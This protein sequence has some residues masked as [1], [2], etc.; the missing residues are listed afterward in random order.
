MYHLTILQ[1]WCGIFH[2]R[3]GRRDTNQE[4]LEY[5]IGALPGNHQY[6]FYAACDFDMVVLGASVEFHQYVVAVR[7]QLVRVTRQLLSS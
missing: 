3:G 6:V 7:T 4:I 5:C 2:R 1:H